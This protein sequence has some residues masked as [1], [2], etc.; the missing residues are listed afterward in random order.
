MVNPYFQVKASAR[1]LSETLQVHTKRPWQVTAPHKVLES[2]R[3][4][5]GIASRVYGRCYRAPRGG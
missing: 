4:V 2:L 1:R 3:E 5:E